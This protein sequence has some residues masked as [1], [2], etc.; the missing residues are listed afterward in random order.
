MS[1]DGE[2]AVASAVADIDP[3]AHWTRM[4]DYIEEQLIPAD[5]VL[6]ATLDYTTAQGYPDHLHVAANQGMLL[7]MLIRISGSKRVLEL[8]TFA[9]YSTL[10]MA[11]YLPEDGYIL[12]IE[13]REP[14]F[15]LAQANFT[16][17]QLPVSID[18]R[19]GKVADVISDL[20]PETA[21]FDF[22][23][24]DADKQQYAHYLELCLQRARPGT[25]MLFDNVI[26]AGEV[27]NPD[28]QRIMMQ[29]LRQFFER[30]HQHPRIEL[31]TA[32]QT[33]GCKGHDGFALLRVK[34]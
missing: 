26:R 33:V 8:G 15:A 28:N 18:L 31:S 3:Q 30:L 22:I 27:A 17:S 29:G 1:A 5:A 34:D 2:L 9:G 32:L 16:R 10:W 19:L 11:R 6:Q 21:P 4:D 14:H 25:L 7:A 23:F 20:P 12:T 24:I 13:G